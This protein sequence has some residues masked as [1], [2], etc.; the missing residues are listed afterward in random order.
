MRNKSTQIKKKDIQKKKKEREKKLLKNQDVK[1]YCQSIGKIWSS[2]S[3]DSFL[4]VLVFQGTQF[5]M[6]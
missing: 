6:L 3:H 4:F 2:L 5:P 1:I